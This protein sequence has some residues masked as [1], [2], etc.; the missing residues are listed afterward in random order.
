[1][2]DPKYKEEQMRQA[3]VNKARYD[4]KRKEEILEKDNPFSL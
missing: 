3:R 2:E 1:M 4:T